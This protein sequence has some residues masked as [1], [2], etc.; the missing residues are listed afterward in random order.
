MVVAMLIHC[1]FVKSLMIYQHNLT[2]SLNDTS[3]VQP[4]FNTGVRPYNIII[5]KL[6]THRST[7]YKI[8]LI[9]R[10]TRLCFSFLYTELDTEFSELASLKI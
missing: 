3:H 10:D 9:N 5:W 8:G 1:I 7:K 2:Q 6:A 4:E